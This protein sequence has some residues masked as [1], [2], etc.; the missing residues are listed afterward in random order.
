[1]RNHNLRA[2]DDTP[3]ASGLRRGT[4]ERGFILVRAA[5][6]Q[7]APR[8]AAPEF[9]VRRPRIEHFK[10]VMRPRF[11]SPAP[12]ALRPSNSWMGRVA[13]PIEAV[14]IFDPPPNTGQRQAVVKTSC[15]MR[16][17]RSTSAR[18]VMRGPPAIF[19]TEIRKFRFH[20]RKTYG[21]TLQSQH[22]GRLEQRAIGN[23]YVGHKRAVCCKLRQ[24]NR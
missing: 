18:R 22:F 9:A 21:C 1:M 7:A 13:S 10:D 3:L 11:S 14:L 8:H 20:E 4:F 23:L 12:F 16:S 24:Y 2:I 6:V 19:D 17:T 5:T 15:L